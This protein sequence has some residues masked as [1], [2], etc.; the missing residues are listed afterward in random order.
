MIIITNSSDS[1]F[2]SFLGVH[3]VFQTQNDRPGNEPG[4]LV[5]RLGAKQRPS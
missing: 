4:R 1:F 2:H 3:Y 5:L